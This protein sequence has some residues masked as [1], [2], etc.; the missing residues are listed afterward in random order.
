[1]HAA[2][3]VMLAAAA[4]PAATATPTA[5]HPASMAEH[6]RACAGK[7]GWADPAPPIRIFANVYDIG[8]CGITVPLIVGSA[9]AIVI[10]AATAQAVPN[11]LANIRRLGLRPRDVKILLSS[12]EHQDHAGGLAALK[13]A[14]GAQMIATVVARPMLERAVPAADDPQR[15]SS[16]P[17]FAGVRVDRVIR[18]GG[19]VTLGDLRLTAHATPGHA[20]GSTSW[21]WRSC[22]GTTCRRIAYADSVSAV[23]NDAYRFVDHPAYVR[24]FRAALATVAALPCDLIVTPHP[25][26]SD[27]YARL[28]GR[29]PLASPSAC[30]DYAAAG[31]AALD[32][33][34]AKE[35]QTGG[36][37]LL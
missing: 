11:I 24:R 35:R 36:K 10:D 18:D 6:R 14:T 8:S 17:E 13:R 1:M 27:L 33:R 30:R 12:H 16:R 37:P 22:A 5:L 19:V 26:A 23:S 21:T 29:K 9:G 7:E 25:G 15:T 32:A 20:P 2:L 4:S 28:D 34:L 3:L 31:R